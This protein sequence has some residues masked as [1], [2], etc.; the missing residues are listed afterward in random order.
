[1]NFWRYFVFLGSLAVAMLMVGACGSA[2]DVS[3]P[4]VSSSTTL[5]SM[6][7]PAEYFA[8]NNGWIQVGGLTLDL[9]F[10]CYAPGAGAGAGAGDLVAV[11]V[12]KHPV[13]GRAV[14]ALIQ[15]FLGRPY[16]G[17]MLGDEVVYEAALE[18]P[19][20]VYMHNDKITAGAIRW[21]EDVDLKSGE[22]ESAGFGALFVDCPS[23]Q[24]GL[25]DGY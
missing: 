5:P 17:V 10:T 12:G 23:Y 13:S 14:K 6:P 22:G 20:E 15:G 8:P 19:L 24:S 16:V 3:F 7:N 11:G 1:V 2:G 9:V 18:D 25:P 21:Q 4:Q